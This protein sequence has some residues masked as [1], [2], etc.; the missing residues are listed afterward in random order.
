MSYCIKRFM[1]TNLPPVFTFYSHTKQ[2][3]NGDEWLNSLQIDCRIFSN[4]YSSEVII[5]SKT[6]SST[7]TYFQQYKYSEGDK[8]F[9]C[10]LSS[11]GDVAAFGQ[12]RLKM[13]RKHIN[14]IEQLKEEGK[15]I[16]LTPGGEEY[17][18]KDKAS[19][20]LAIEDWDIQK[21]ILFYLY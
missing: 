4:L 7:E 17:K 18:V 8:N 9:L 6:Y 3:T 2:I 15:A 13:A 10:A 14:L 11:M 21:V 19:P 20:K 12:R 16:P 5:D 1:S